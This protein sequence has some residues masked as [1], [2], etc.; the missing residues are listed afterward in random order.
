MD[1]AYEWYERASIAIQKLSPKD[2]DFIVVSVPSNMDP[3]QIEMVS[4]L[5]QDA[6]A[7]YLP[8]GVKSLILANGIEIRKIDEQ[9][10]NELGWYRKNE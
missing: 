3:R 10:M 6:F 7:D 4:V 1:L 2:G 5:L 9:Q 8:T